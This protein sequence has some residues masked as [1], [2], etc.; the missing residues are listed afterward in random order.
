[1]SGILGALHFQQHIGMTKTT[2]MAAKLLSAQRIELA[3]QALAGAANVSHLAAENEVSRKFVHQQKDK[4]RIALD[5]AF[6]A[7]VPDDT[8][9]FHLPGTKT[10]LNQLTLSLTLIRHSS[11]QGVAELMLDLLGGSGRCHPP[12]PHPRCNV[13]QRL[14]RQA[15]Q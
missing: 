9:L 6:A 2:F 14:L 13:H 1:M 8:V 3:I 12:P 7:T 15:A 11:Y 10:W 5:E 4:A